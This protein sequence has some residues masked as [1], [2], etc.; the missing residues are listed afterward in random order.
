MATSTYTGRL[1]CCGVGTDGSIVMSPLAQAFEALAS[2]TFVV[3][4]SAGVVGTGVVGFAVALG[5]ADGNAVTVAVLVGAGRSSGWF[6][7]SLTTI[8]ATRNAAASRSN[9]RRTY[10]E[11]GR[12]LLLTAPR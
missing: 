6:G 11:R 9:R 5:D 3:E 8:Q 7:H 4:P 10:T 12:C 1:A 2:A